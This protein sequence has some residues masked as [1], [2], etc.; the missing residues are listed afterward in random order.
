MIPPPWTEKQLQHSGTIS[1]AI[2][3]VVGYTPDM[4]RVNPTLEYLKRTAV[5]AKAQRSNVWP[6][7]SGTRFVRI[8]GGDLDGHAHPTDGWYAPHVV[9]GQ[10]A[11]LEWIVPQ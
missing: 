9:E 6:A 2:D 7:P 4:L 10:L 8:Y 1:N 3:G 5:K 11:Y